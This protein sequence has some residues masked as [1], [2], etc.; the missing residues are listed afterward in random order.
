MMN[1]RATVRKTAI[2]L[3]ALL[4]MALQ[5][6]GTAGAHTVKSGA[7]FPSFAEFDM[8]TGKLI[9]LEKFRGKV[10]LIDFWATW[11][12]PCIA[13]IPQVKKIYKKYHRQG[14]EIIGISLDSSV[15]KCQSYVKKNEMDWHHICDGRGWRS[16]IAQKYDVSGIPLQVVVGKDGKVVSVNARGERLEAAVKKALDEEYTPEPLDEIEQAAQAEL[17]KADVL[18]ARGQFSEALKVYDEIGLKYAARPTGK[19]ANETARVLREDPEILAQI[20][21]TKNEKYERE[22]REFGRKWIKVARKMAA[23]GKHDL[24][25]RYYQKVL[26]KFPGSKAAKLAEKEFK[27]LPE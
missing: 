27:Q 8:N 2:S 18:R 23:G 1:I 17:A 19:L 5:G 25:R 24:A 14:F 9:E 11:C 3:A 21:D 7:E 16:K 22:A 10:V 4:I 6:G 13:E 15:S 26:D 20:E 12:G